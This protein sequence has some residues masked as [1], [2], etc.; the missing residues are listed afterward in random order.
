LQ[1]E[2]ETGALVA[3]IGQTLL[4]AIADLKAAMERQFT[5]VDARLALLTAMRAQ[6]DGL[7]LISRAVTVVQQDVRAL[8]VA[9]N[10]F[11]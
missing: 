1:S 3:D 4:D 2:L 6:L 11:A 10:D 8:R 9:F 7:P 5:A